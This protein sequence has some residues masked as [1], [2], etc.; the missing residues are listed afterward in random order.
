MRVG[1]RDVAAETF[2]AE[3]DDES[4][5]FNRFDED[6]DARNRDRLQQLNNFGAFFRRDT[7]GA[8]IR[9]EPV[10]VDRAEV[11]TNAHIVRSDRKRNASRFQ[12][13]ATDLE[14]ERVVTE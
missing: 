12:N 1:V 2:A 8:T 14:N 13:A 10:L 5:L 4:M 6:F 3:Y 9:N 7:S 11:A